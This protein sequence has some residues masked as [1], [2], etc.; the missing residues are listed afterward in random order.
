MLSSTSDP[1]LSTRSLGGAGGG[2]GGGGGVG[3]LPPFDWEIDQQL[4]EAAL[5]PD[6]LVRF[7]HGSQD[8]AQ[9]SKHHKGAFAESRTTDELV[10][11]EGG[12]ARESGSAGYFT[13]SSSTGGGDGGERKGDKSRGA[14]EGD[15]TASVRARR[16]EVYQAQG[17]N[18]RC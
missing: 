6:D 3:F 11:G 5:S 16:Q 2:G 18:V 12:D 4:V 7:L 1:V 8:E 14:V 9:S 15:P 10:E 13:L 17:A